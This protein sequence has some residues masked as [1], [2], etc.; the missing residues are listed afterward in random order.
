METLLNALFDMA[1]I[2]IVV[3]IA[4]IVGC[5][6]SSAFDNRRLPRRPMA[7]RSRAGRHYQGK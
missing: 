4:F 2:A 7:T 6:V 3:S 1:I 5:F